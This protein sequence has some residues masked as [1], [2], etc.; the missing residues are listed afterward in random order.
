MQTDGTWSLGLPSY[1]S[2][3]YRVA[4]K[5]ALST[6]VPTSDY[7]HGLGSASQNCVCKDMAAFFQ[8]QVAMAVYCVFAAKNCLGEVQELFILERNCW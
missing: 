1:H 8:V 2:F 4:A 3:L 6:L 7:G 5:K